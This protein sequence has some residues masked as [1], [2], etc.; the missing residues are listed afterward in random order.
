MFKIY[1]TTNVLVLAASINQGP[2]CAVIRTSFNLSTLIT[3]HEMRGN[4]MEYFKPGE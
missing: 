2:C 3:S 1:V 4:V